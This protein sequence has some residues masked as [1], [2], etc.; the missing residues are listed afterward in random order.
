MKTDTQEIYAPKTAGKL[1]FR[2]KFSYGLG[3]M[4]SNL[5]WGMVTTY[6]LFFYTDVLQLG[7]ASIS[8]LFVIARLWD[9]IND[10]I[11][12]YLADRTRTKWGR[13]RPY[14]LFGPIFL[15]AATFLCFTVPDV[16]AESKLIYAYITYIFLGVSYTVV[17]MPYGALAA[18]M[19]QNTDERSSLSGFR[20]FFAIVGTIVVSLV[21][22]PLVQYFGGSATS[23]YGF[24]MTA[25]I[26]AAIL[27][28]LYFIVFKGTREVIKP[29]KKEK[30]PLKVLGSTILKNRP[31]ILILITMLLSCTCLFI[32]QSMLIYYFTYVVGNESFTSLF[33]GLMSVMMLAGILL[34]SPV[35]KRIGKKATM[36][37]GLSVFGVCSFGMYFTGPFNMTFLY[38]WI[39]VGSVFSGFTYVMLWSMLADTIEYA[40]LKTGLRAD[41][42]IFAAA[43][44]TMKLAT[45]LA[46]GGTALLLSLSGYVAKASQA[47]Q[48]LSAINLS[49]TI[50]P[51]IILGI[52]VIPLLF[53]TL[54]KKKFN[55][56]VLEIEERKLA[57]SNQ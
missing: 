40:E 37:T 6:L 44:F 8:L 24:S 54:N 36:L 23:S 10:P 13:F 19:T 51:G 5:C 30:I 11:M 33:L 25:L 45:A 56:I 1:N 21:T 47:P 16:N 15:A 39:I 26:Y 49:V 43:G 42:L 7:L 3:D 57:S 20:M 34:A 14:V 38:V 2:S 9:A 35:S 52:S 32:R 28:P 27:L 18:S 41:G 4:A 12:G 48:A 22:L 17:N 46:G 29:E 53:H 50:L 31:L 55:Q